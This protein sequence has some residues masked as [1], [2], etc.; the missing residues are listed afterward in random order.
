MKTACGT[1]LFDGCEV[2]LSTGSAGVAL[3][4]INQPSDGSKAEDPA[5]KKKQKRSFHFSKH[6]QGWTP[7]QMALLRP[8]SKSNVFFYPLFASHCCS[9][10]SDCDVKRSIFKNSFTD[11]SL[12]TEGAES[13]RFKV[14]RLS[15]SHP[16]WASFEYSLSGASVRRARKC[17][18]PSVQP[19]SNVIKWSDV[20]LEVDSRGRRPT[21]VLIWPELMAVKMLDFSLFCLGRCS[22]QTNSRRSD[23]EAPPTPHQPRSPHKPSPSH[24]PDD[25]AKERMPAPSV[26]AA[27]VIEI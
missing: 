1:W 21:S 22:V 3:Q 25:D 19:K 24:S 17:R 4:E 15:T 9:R 12:N 5:L 14:R 6:L 18:R 10:F 20:R 11:G 7:Y 2:T 16:F 26:D 23:P 8:N 13:F 27:S